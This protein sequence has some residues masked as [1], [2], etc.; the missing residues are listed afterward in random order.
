MNYSERR[1]M[2]VKIWNLDVKPY[3]MELNLPET[4]TAYPHL[5]ITHRY[6]R[7]M[8]NLI[9]IRPGPIVDL[10]LNE[11][12][13]TL[14]RQIGKREEDPF[15]PP[16]VEGGVKFRVETKKYKRETML[17]EK[18][19]DK[20]KFSLLLNYHA[21]S[22]IN[23]KTYAGPLLDIFLMNGSMWLVDAENKEMSIM[24]SEKKFDVDSS[25]FTYYDQPF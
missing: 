4:T 19:V 20:L 24:S 10:F 25:R 21:T 11:E 14:K 9:T 8:L 12:N 15:S 6:T 5:R 23:V 22:I 3:R 18:E 16:K 13:L 7:S 2:K 17:P 1:K